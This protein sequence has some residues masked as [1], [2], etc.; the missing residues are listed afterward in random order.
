MRACPFIPIFSYVQLNRC[1]QGVSLGELWHSLDSQIFASCAG[2]IYLL[3]KS[4]TFY[5]RN[6]PLKKVHKF[7]QEISDH[8]SC[9]F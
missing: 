4:P 5:L 8:V 6:K 2:H 1:N 3:H 9:V 7:K